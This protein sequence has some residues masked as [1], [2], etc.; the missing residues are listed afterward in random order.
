[1]AKLASKTNVV[2]T[3][4]WRSST[5]I[6]REIQLIKKGNDYSLI[7]NPVKEIN[8][9]IAKTIKIKSL[10]GKGKLSIPDA[11]KI[12]L[13]KAII[14]FNVKNLKQDTYTFTL[15]NTTGE[16]LTFGINNTDHY[17]FVDRSKSGRID[18]SEKFASTIT[19]AA[20]EGNQKEGVFKIILDK[21]S[22]EIF[23]NNGQKVITEIFFPNQPYTSF[24]V[25]SKNGF[26]L[27]NLEIN[28][29][30]IK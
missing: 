27:N 4:G 29:L 8:K 23:Y 11:G 26:E 5:T 20:L 6:A 7:S 15:S 9:Y 14:H 12:D 25:S 22:I 28:Q 24:S 3:T 10:K 2:P 30:N 21:T 19:K 1:M 13:T 16:A 18:F 17:L